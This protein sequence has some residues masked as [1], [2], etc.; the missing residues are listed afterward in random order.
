M[1]NQGLF[2]PQT[3]RMSVQNFAV[4]K[5]FGQIHIAQKV[6]LYASLVNIHR[7]HWDLMICAYEVYLTENPVRLEEKS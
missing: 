1:V 4:Q 7:F 5:A 3:A 6:L 2:G